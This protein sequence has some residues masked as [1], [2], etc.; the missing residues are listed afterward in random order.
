MAPT[1]ERLP[2]PVAI[3]AGEQYARQQFAEEMKERNADPMNE[4]K[5]PGGITLRADGTPTD[6]NNIPIPAKD[7]N[8]Q[9]AES[10]RQHV[11][12]A[13]P[14]IGLPEGYESLG[15]AAAPQSDTGSSGTGTGTGTGSGGTPAAGK[16]DELTV[17]ELKAA[18]SDRGVAT[19]ATRK[20]DLIA[21]LEADDKAKAQG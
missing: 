21:A 4:S 16:Y 1:R 13:R 2:S 12:D 6:A 10:I 20:A 9:E 15:G 8:A 18:I 17:A 11:R 5:R 14:P 7:L 3:L 19:D